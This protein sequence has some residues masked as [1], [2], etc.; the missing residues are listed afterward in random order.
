M[1]PEVRVHR[2][3][4]VRQCPVGRVVGQQYC[5]TDSVRRVRDDGLYAPYVL[6]EVIPADVL[7]AVVLES[8]RFA[9]LQGL[10]WSSLILQLEGE[11]LSVLFDPNVDMQRFFSLSV[12][13]SRV[14]RGY[15]VFASKTHSFR[16][17][18]L[19]ENSRT[20]GRS[21]SSEFAREQNAQPYLGARSY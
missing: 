15:S 20:L 17:P 1:E 5:I 13:D 9:S 6:D 14:K 7:S 8:E 11:D 2:T 3:A 19:A 21:S 12:K 18:A 16:R 10:Q 4:V